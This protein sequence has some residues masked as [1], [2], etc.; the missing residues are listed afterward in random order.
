M[1]IEALIPVFLVIALGHGLRRIGF[2][3]DAFWPLMEQVTYFVIFPCFLFST[4]AGGNLEGYDIGPM[5]L[6]L[7]GAV[8]CMALL[9]YALWP[10]LGLSGRQFSS[11]FQTTVRWNGFVALAAIGSLYGKPGL[12]LAAVSF[13]VL[14]PLANLLC[15]YVVTRT[16]S[17]Q[18]VALAEMGRL[19]LTNPLLIGCAAGI[20][21]NGAALPVPASLFDTARLIGTAAVPLGLLAVGASLDLAAARSSVIV[22]SA[23]S[24]M[25]LLLMPALMLGACK[26]FGVEGTAMAVAV[27]CGGTPTA[28][29]AYILARQ[30]GGDAPLMANLITATT[31]GAMLTLPLVISLLAPG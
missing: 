2:P 30:L 17:G 26:L 14:V 29:S 5:T 10:I 12:A 3:G 21:V 11:F 7:I 31:L 6:A 27:I 20:I 16:A 1:I 8:A 28:T 22:I 9:T 18:P 24:A 25:R 23:A 4:I 19:L 13:G 15:V